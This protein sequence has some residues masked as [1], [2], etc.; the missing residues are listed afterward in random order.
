MSFDFLNPSSW[1]DPFVDAA[2]TVGDAAQ[3]VARDA[4][5]LAEV[6]GNDIVDG[7]KLIG[8][9]VITAGTGAEKWGMTAAGDAISWSKTSLAEVRD[10]TENAA[11]SVEHFTVENFNI[12]KNA[13]EAG[14]V[15]AYQQLA[16]FFYETLPVLGPIDPNAEHLASYLL[17]GVVADGLKSA[18]S[19]TGCVITFGI[20]IKLVLTI[21]LGVYVCGDGWGFFAGP[22]P[23]TIDSI[24]QKLATPGALTPSVSAQVT[25]V[26][27][28]VARASGAHAIKFGLGMEA[29]PSKNLGVN[30]GGV[31]LMEASMP[32]L[33]LGLRYA[34]GL[35]LKLFGKTKE[36][37]SDPSSVKWN[38]STT[39]PSPNGN[40]PAEV[41]SGAG[42]LAEIG[43]SDVTG[44]LSV[45]ANH[46][47]A[48][49]RAHA[50]PAAADRIQATALAATSGQFQPRYYG[51]IRTAS[52]LPLVGTSQGA[53]GVNSPGDRPVVCIVAG[54]TDPSCVSIEAIGEPPLLLRRRQRQPEA[55]TLR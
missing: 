45:Q 18:A 26:F 50:N 2:N 47:D 52:G 11:G 10:W 54:L 14:M 23:P 49:L 5:S 44:G 40:L 33:F 22:Q 12:A 16:S 31:V 19:A 6:V 37:V 25:M 17:T 43:W 29:S 46:F 9:G 30:I 53:L 42:N 7:A 39:L 1:G 35:D 20:S 36:Q 48:A 27:G 4:V 28:P 13:V 34:M 8:D 38:L 21:N 15:W 51:T 24:A 3:S 32:P 41:A 55:G